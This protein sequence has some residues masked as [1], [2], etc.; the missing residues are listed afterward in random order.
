MGLVI[1]LA[2]AIGNHATR[3]K[4]VKLPEIPLPIILRPPIRPPIYTTPPLSRTPPQTM[5]LPDPQ[6]SDQS[7]S[8][9]TMLKTWRGSVLKLIKLAHRNS[10]LAQQ[11]LQKG[12]CW[13]AMNAAVTSME[14]MSRALLHCFG[15]MPEP[16]SGQDEALRLLARRLS[17]GE[18]QEFQK[19]IDESRKLREKAAAQ[20]LL[21]QQQP[22]PRPIPTRSTVTPIILSS[23]E[24]I[25]AIRQIINRHFTSE[26]PE[27]LA[28]CPKC[29]S[30]DVSV[31]A[32]DKTTTV[33]IC[34]QCMH[35]WIGQS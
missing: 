13:F 11:L 23:T 14:N 22:F 2:V 5:P 15:E 32:F 34:S 21:R 28:D 4:Q 33:Y 17:A 27:L 12:E 19:I 25:K 30:P 26:I 3:K 9:Q 35:K 10:F 31:L 7:V 18:K 24:I 8:T 16:N 6:T 20:N 1:G 29:Q